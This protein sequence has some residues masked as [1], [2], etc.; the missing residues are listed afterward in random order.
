MF[1]EKFALLMLHS[2]VLLCNLFVH[3]KPELDFT[4]S[5]NEVISLLLAHV[6]SSLL[7]VPKNTHALK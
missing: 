6:H 3:V 1:L 4:R 5:L 2:V 7:R